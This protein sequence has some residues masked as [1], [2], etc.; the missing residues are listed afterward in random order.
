MDALSD[1]AEVKREI[2]DVEE[3]LAQVKRILPMIQALLH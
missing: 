2:T 1:L 3:D